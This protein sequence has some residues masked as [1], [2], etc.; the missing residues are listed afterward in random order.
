VSTE[1]SGDE[2]PTLQNVTPI[3]RIQP[4]STSVTEWI[5]STMT[6]DKAAY[7]LV[8]TP[9]TRFHVPAEHL[10]NRKDEFARLRAMI[11]Q[12]DSQVWLSRQF[13][14]IDEKPDQDLTPLQQE[15]WIET[16]ERVEWFGNE[17]DRRIRE[18]F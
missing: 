2:Y 5:I 13:A 4:L 18:D 1:Y 3:R 7:A 6:P 9:G 16:L 11:E 8:L 14:V 10:I 12:W 17:I 15:A